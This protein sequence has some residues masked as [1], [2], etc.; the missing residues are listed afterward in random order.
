MGYYYQAMLFD[1]DGQSY[2]PAGTPLPRANNAPP[3]V[4]TNANRFGFTAFPDRYG[5]DGLISFIV[6]EDGV[7]WHKDTG[8]APPEMN[9]STGPLP[10]SDTTWGQ[11]SG[12][13]D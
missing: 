10:G 2:L 1:Q 12:D 9:R 8:G 11:F 13:L 7:I 5:Y 4:C 6:N 3:G